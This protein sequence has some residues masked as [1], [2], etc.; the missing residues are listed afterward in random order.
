[1]TLALVVL[2]I[3]NTLAQSTAPAASTL[4]REETWRADLRYLA[5]ELPKR[6]KDL[7]FHLKQPDFERSIAQLDNAIPKLQDYEIIVKM[8][9]KPSGF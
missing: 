8:M 4:T 7:F 1:L 3:G 2:L 6:H 9:S 5:T